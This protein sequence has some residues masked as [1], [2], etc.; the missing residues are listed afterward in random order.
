[1]RDFPQTLLIA[2]LLLFPCLLFPAPTSSVADRQ[3]IEEALHWVRNSPRRLVQYAYV[4][5]ARVHLLFLWAGKDGG[6]GGY[7]R[8]GVSAEDPRM[9]FI[10]VLVGSDPEKALAPSIVGE[11]ARRSP[12]TKRPPPPRTPM[13]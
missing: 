3:P 1:M 10:Q 11:Q 13:T 5:T 6:G 7:I 4:M 2:F 8:R 9:E 12:G